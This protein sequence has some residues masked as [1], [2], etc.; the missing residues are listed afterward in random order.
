MFNI[1][2][3][4]EDKNDANDENSENLEP[5]KS[6]V[7]AV[8]EVVFCLLMQKIPTLNS[9]A[10]GFQVKSTG[11]IK[12]NDALLEDTVKCLELLPD[13]CSDIGIIL[14]IVYLGSHTMQI[15]ILVDNIVYYISAAAVDVQPTILY[16]ST[17]IL[18]ESVASDAACTSVLQFYRKIATHR[19]NSNPK[20][21][22]YLLC[23]LAKLLDMAKTGLS[24][25]WFY[26]N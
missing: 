3:E 17:Y 7:I 9:N 25:D 4:A 26:S 14:I 16:L 23:T 6:V 5:G 12:E 1:F 2:L 15:I 20:W 11:T 19:L 8:L 21:Q 13:I 22:K 10:T 24:N 18:G